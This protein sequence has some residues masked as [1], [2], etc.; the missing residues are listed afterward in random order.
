VREK[1]KK[2]KQAKIIKNKK[3][4]SENKN[5]QIFWRTTQKKFLYFYQRKVFIAY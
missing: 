2:N 4:F 1:K 5:K 3:L